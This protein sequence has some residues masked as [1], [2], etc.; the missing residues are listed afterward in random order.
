LVAVLLGVAFAAVVDA[1][2]E[3]ELVVGVGVALWVKDVDVGINGSVHWSL[4]QDMPFG[5]QESPHVAKLPFK[6]VENNGLVGCAVAFCRV[7][8]QFSGDIEVQFFA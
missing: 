7:I 4:T 2:L 8:S 6:S 1:E 5:Q 3:V